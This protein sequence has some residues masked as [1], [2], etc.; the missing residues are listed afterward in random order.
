MNE[1]D[2]STTNVELASGCFDIN[3]NIVAIVP[4]KLF[5]LRVF[6]WST[7]VAVFSWCV[8]CV[9]TKTDC[10][11]IGE[12]QSPIPVAYLHELDILSCKIKHNS[13]LFP[14]CS[15]VIPC[16]LLAVMSC[17]FCFVFMISCLST[18]PP[19]GKSLVAVTTLREWFVH[20]PSIPA[21]VH[22]PAT[23][24]ASVLGPLGIFEYQHLTVLVVFK[25][26]QIK[27]LPGWLWGH[28]SDTV[29]IGWQ[30]IGSKFLRFSSCTT[31]LAIFFRPF[32]PPDFFL[33]TLC[34]SL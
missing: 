18:H 24:P 21:A 31:T 16:A 2:K 30:N 4:A 26:Q 5:S 6:G 17:L 27:G 29:W 11:G 22:I 9:G 34:V 15:S 25:W 10:R 28:F 33:N 3:V 12:I 8:G 20:Q 13:I 19:A 32:K 7:Q 1:H 14:R 23:V